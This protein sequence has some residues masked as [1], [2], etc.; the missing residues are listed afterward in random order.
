M[1]TLRQL[2]VHF[3]IKHGGLHAES[4][5]DAEK[6]AGSA[7]VES[8]SDADKSAGSADVESES[9]ADKA[10]SDEGIN[11]A[12]RDFYLFFKSILNSEYYKSTLSEDIVI[13]LSRDRLDNL[14]HE[15][16]TLRHHM[17]FT[18][19]KAFFAKRFFWNFKLYCKVSL[20]MSACHSMTV[21]PCLSY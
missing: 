17:A 5:S 6:T 21:C 3:Q 7:V 19:Y 20:S 1:N 14:D 18:T 4:E 8:E 9:D 13:Q 15:Y 11:L 10:A 16:I 2:L 12:I